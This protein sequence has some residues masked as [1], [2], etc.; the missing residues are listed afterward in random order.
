MSKEFS[1]TYKK[2]YGSFLKITN[3]DDATEYFCS[4]IEQAGTPHMEWHIEA[5]KDIL[6]GFGGTK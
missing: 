4:S 1:S 6:E 3:L 2:Q 5:A